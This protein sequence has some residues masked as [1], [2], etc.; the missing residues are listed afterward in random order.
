MRILRKNWQDRRDFEADMICEH[1]K[2]IQKDVGG[3]DDA[4]FHK[5]VIPNM[6]C[7]QCGKKA[8]DDYRPMGT[9]YAAHE[10]V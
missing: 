2:H 10:I 5:N 8:S 4:Y 9:K 1:C 6:K 3:Y 7:S